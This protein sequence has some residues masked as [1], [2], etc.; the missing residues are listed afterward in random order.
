MG[1]KILNLLEKFVHNLTLKS[2][3]SADEEF[4][5]GLLATLKYLIE[6]FCFYDTQKQNKTYGGPANYV[7]AKGLKFEP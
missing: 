6:S 7:P 4:K 2:S 1:D 3:N 5:H